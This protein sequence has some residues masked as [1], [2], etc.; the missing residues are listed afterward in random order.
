M[1][2]LREEASDFVNEERSGGDSGSLRF[3][4]GVL[5]DPFL[6]TQVGRSNEVADPSKNLA[7]ALI[8]Y[9]PEPDQTSSI[10]TKNCH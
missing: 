7:R 8:Y 6:S 9:N 1:N 5:F 10:A 2:I 3:G 4:E